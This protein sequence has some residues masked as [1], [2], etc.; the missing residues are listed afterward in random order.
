MDMSFSYIPVLL[1][2]MMEFAKVEG[3]GRADDV[4]DFVETF[5]EQRLEQC[6]VSE[7]SNSIY[8]KGTYTDK[9]GGKEYF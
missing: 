1:M 9:D 8:Q 3:K 2:A 4:V 5:C 6:L 7:K